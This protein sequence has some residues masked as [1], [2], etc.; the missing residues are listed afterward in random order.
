M[1]EVYV[2]LWTIQMSVQCRRKVSNIGGYNIHHPSFDIVHVLFDVLRQKFFKV[3]TAEGCNPSSSVPTAMPYKYRKK[4]QI[5]YSQLTTL[6]CIFCILLIFLIFKY[7]NIVRKKC[8]RFQPFRKFNLS[9]I[10]PCS[11]THKND[12]QNTPWN[13][14]SCLTDHSEIPLNHFEPFRQTCSQITNQN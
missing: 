13:G 2:L 3:K 12:R 9:A 11:F 8:R 6:S 5:D 4:F 1:S 10:N 14:F 7:I